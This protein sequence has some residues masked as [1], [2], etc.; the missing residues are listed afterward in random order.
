MKKEFTAVLVLV[1]I[2]GI[3]WTSGRV[4][5]SDKINRQ[6]WEYKYVTIYDITGAKTSMEL[7]SKGFGGEDLNKKCQ[8]ELNKLGKDGWEMIDVCEKGWMFKR[9]L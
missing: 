4:T 2:A 6:G 8:Q 7:I 3:V 1:I 5:G 9:P